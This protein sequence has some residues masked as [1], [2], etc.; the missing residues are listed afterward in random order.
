MQ[1]GKD[2]IIYWSLLREQQQFVCYILK[3]RTSR[4]SASYSPDP[5]FCFGLEAS[6]F[7]VDSV[8]WLTL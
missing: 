8:V 7:E 2:E 1:I 4:V 6:C 5:R 3:H